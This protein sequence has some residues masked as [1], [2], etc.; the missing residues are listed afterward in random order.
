MYWSPV[1]ITIPPAIGEVH[2]I[3]RP[4]RTLFWVRVRVKVNVRVKASVKAPTSGMQAPFACPQPLRAAAQVR[5]KAFYEPICGNIY[6]YIYIYMVAHYILTAEI[7]YMK[8]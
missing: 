2:L 7:Q 8:M 6:I 1:P 3:W 4:L 5:V